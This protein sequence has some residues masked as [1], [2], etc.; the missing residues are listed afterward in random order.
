MVVYKSTCID[1]EG[2]KPEVNSAEE[3]IFTN[4]VYFKV[5][6]E[7]INPNS[8]EFNTYNTAENS[9]W[10]NAKCTFSYST[11]GTNFKQIG[12]SFA[13]K[14]GKW[15]GAKVGIFAVRKGKTYESGYADFDW[16]RIEK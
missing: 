10:G 6:V 13:A 11:D 8:P 14:K 9:R 4:T 7:N 16:F 1:A 3:Y 2:G 12:D 15:I 5:K